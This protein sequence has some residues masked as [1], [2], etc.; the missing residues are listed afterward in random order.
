MKMNSH[1]SIPLLLVLFLFSGCLPPTPEQEQMRRDVDD[2]KGVT[3]RQ[4]QRLI[5][6]E[7]DL[8]KREALQKDIN[9]MRKE[10][11]LQGQKLASLEEELKKERARVNAS[12]E[13]LKVDMARIEGRFDEGKFEAQRLREAIEGLKAKGVDT[14]EVKDINTRL[15]ATESSLITLE[16]QLTGL[17][18]RDSSLETK[19][20]GLEKRIA[21]LE[22]KVVTV[23]KA[24]EKATVV[25][26][27]KGEVDVLPKT[28][29]SE[30]FRRLQDRDYPSA[31][32]GFKK[33]LASFP[34]HELADNSQYW[35][36]EVYYAQKDYERA[37][38]EFNEVM[39]RYPK[40]DKIPAA[41]LKQALA[42][43]E[44]GNKAEAKILLERVR[45]RYPATEEASL[46]RK[47]LEEMK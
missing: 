35:I 34:D 8:K 12:L 27:V 32:E 45:D 42:F 25:P 5:H 23:E 13:G 46:A 17:G 4:G 1:N 19:I 47:R 7:E 9:D 3:G 6:L 30:A 15:S 21:D 16:K 43:Y 20:A 41:I 24:V 29:Y 38:L 10:S 33:F 44:L 31:L 36:G 37:I 2:L 18:E 22:G 40:G 39:R 11:D 28:L 14:K 26:P